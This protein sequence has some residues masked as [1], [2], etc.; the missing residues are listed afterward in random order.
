MSKKS[1]VFL[2]FAI[3][4]FVLAIGIFIYANTLNK[5]TNESQENNNNQNNIE[6]NENKPDGFVFYD[7]NGNEFGISNYEGTPIALILWSSDTE[8]SFE[9]VEMIESVYNDYKNDITFLVINTEEKSESITETIA[10]IGYSFQ[11]YY[12]TDNLAANYYEYTKLPSLIFLN[13]DGTKS[14]QIEGS[15]TEDSLLANLDLIAK[16]Y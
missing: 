6:T 9:V 14:N 11:I 13:A 16:N 10:N 12:D 15:I 4:F 3:I 7:E 8:N 5:N 2:V 1:I